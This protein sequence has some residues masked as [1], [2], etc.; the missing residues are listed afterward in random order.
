MTALIVFL[1]FILAAAN[2]YL[3]ERKLPDR[4]P[5]G[6]Q[7]AS[8]ALILCLACLLIL[9]VPEG[10]EFFRIS[11]ILSSGLSLRADGFRSVYALITAFMWS[12]TSLFAMEY[13]EEERENLNRYRFFMLFT[14]GVTEGVMLSADFMTAFVFFEILSFTSFTW[15]IHEESEAA[16]RA[17]YTYLF[18]AVIGGLL[19]FM[20]LL[21][22]SDAAGTLV[23]SALKSAVDASPKKGQIFAAGILILFG[24]GAKAGMFPLHVWLPKAHPI[25]PSPASALLSGVLTKVGIYGILMTAAVL[26]SGSPLFGGIVLAL[27]ILTMFGGALLALLSV[28]LKRTLACSSMS[29]IGF[30]LIGI[31]MYVLLCASGHSEE[32]PVAVFGIFLHMMSHSMVKLTLFMA[33]GVFVMDLGVLSLNELRGTGRRTPLLAAVFAVGGLGLSGVPLFS[34]YLSKILLHEA[35]LEGIHVKAAGEMLLRGTEWIFLFSGGLTFAYMLKLF[36]CVFVEKKPDAELQSEKEKPLKEE[37]LKMRPRSNAARL[38]SALPVLLLGQ[39]GIALNAAS[40]MAGGAFAKD[41]SLLLEGGFPGSFTAFSAENLKGSLI[42]LSIGALLYLFVVKKVLYREGS[43]V[44]LWPESLD[45]EERLYRP[46]LTRVFP[47]IL[48]GIASFFGNEFYKPLFTRYL[49]AFFGSVIAVYGENSILKK[50]CS[51]F[52]RV[53]LQLSH[54]VSDSLDALVLLLRRTLFRE[55]KTEQSVVSFDRS[56]RVLRESIHN[57][58]EPLLMNFTFAMLMTCLGILLILGSLMVMIF[59]G[60]F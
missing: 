57:T 13:F 42:S 47:G 37:P 30:I 29:Q 22:L 48:G 6:I 26:L 40:F 51:L 33:A 4:I 1:P 25:A 44:N 35:I 34:G 38:F 45:L 5:D 11:G 10:Q 58:A 24:F 53:F 59:R 19:L 39:P 55:K 18:I 31:G 3:G 12:M 14:L 52:L 46:L 27:G 54:L 9:R 49:P 41:A 23:F 20:G 50:L 7:A 8:S 36:F 28:N 15:V 2:W 56:F 32:A 17:G 21:L 43:Y 16:I 60:L